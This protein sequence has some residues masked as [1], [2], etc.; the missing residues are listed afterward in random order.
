MGALLAYRG[1]YYLSPLAV[2]VLMLLVQELARRS[3]ALRAAAQAASRWSS[4]IVPPLLGLATLAAGAVLL[5][6]GATAAVPARM[7][8]LER[9]L[10]LP[11]VETSHFL[12]SIA[13]V[14]LLFLARGLFRRLDAAYL[15]T[16][17]LLGA[18]M[19]FSLL[20][21]FD[22][23]EA[24]ILGVMLAALLPA[25]RYFYRKS[26]LFAAPL[27]PAWL[28]AI[29]FFVLCTLWLTFF[30]YKHVEYSNELWW[31]FTFSGNAPRSLRALAGSS[32]AALVLALALLLRPHHRPRAAMAA[33]QE[34]LER[35]LPIVRSSPESYANLALLGDKEFLFSEGGG[36]FLMYRRSGRSWIAMGDP[37]GNPEEWPE[38]AWSFRERADRVGGWAVFYEVGSGH[39]SLYLDLGLTLLKLGEEARVPLAEFSLEGGARKGLR[40]TMNKL[41]KEGCTFET[42]PVEALPALLPELREISEDWLAHKNTREKS[43]SLGSFGEDYLCRFPAGLVRSGGRIVAF[44]NIWAGDNREELSI[45]L[46]RHLSDAPG[47]V[48]EYLFIRLMLWAKEQG[49]HWFNLGMVPLAGLPDHA[50]APLWNRV[51]TLLFRHGEHFYNFQGLRRFK[52][53]FDPVWTPRYLAGPGGLALPAVL[54]NLAALVSGGLKGVVAK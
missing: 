45:D 37:I 3:T 40:Y 35:A 51:G 18:G 24:I 34:E 54:T 43:F 42:A 19:V 15:L 6:S 53:K 8:W 29:F 22:Y 16:A 36:A 52:E 14:A 5:F 38:L 32:V 7:A 17:V 41:E 27:S 28:A 49:Y 20:K 13:G 26:S 50:L 31:K 44:T 33:G 2:A 25:R 4:A 1:V 46:M 9:A 10:P 21:G 11:V 47:G 48:M 23:E 39:L 30:A 12:G